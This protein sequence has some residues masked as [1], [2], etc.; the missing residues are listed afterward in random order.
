MIVKCDLFVC[1]VL[2]FVFPF[3]TNR[4][5]DTMYGKTLIVIIYLGKKL[6]FCHLT[7]A[8]YEKEY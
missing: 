7:L 6:H 5:R 3:L 1:L 4:K 8:P 2:V